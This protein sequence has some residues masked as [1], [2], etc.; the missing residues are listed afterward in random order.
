METKKH[1][2]FYTPEG[3]VHITHLGHG[4]VHLD[5]EG[6]HIYID[7]YLPTA[8]YSKLKK[9]DIIFLT[10]AHTDHYDCEAIMAISTPNTRFVVSKAVGTCVAND[11]TSK[12]I[13]LDD[14]EYNIDPSTNIE[15]M[16]K[17]ISCIKHSKIDVLKNGDK[18]TCRGIN[19]EAVPAYNVKR[20][21]SNGKP[22]HIKGEGNGYILTIGGFRIYFAGDTEFIPEM[23]AAKGVDIAF[24]PKNEPYT[25]LDDE[26]IMAAN[27]I[28]PKNL[29]PIHYFEID[30]KILQ[31]GLEPGICLYI[32]GNQVI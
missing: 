27:F 1:N 6:M 15:N 21:R 11:L 10:H 28:K 32:E 9:A 22:Y 24:L 20:F 7:P 25:M 4:S 5:W 13:D 23:K 16:F 31:K 26:F 14:N 2:T 19:V 29:F 30:P 3:L 8:D 18:L 12:R 17:T